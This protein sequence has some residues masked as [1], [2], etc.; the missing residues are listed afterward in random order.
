MQTKNIFQFVASKI[1]VVGTNSS[2]LKNENFV[3]VNQMMNQNA[4]SCIFS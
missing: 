3:T 2:A 1:M 4:Q